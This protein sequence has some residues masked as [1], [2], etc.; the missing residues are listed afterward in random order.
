MAIR[1]Y[2]ENGNTLYEIY[3]HVKSTVDPLV[4]VQRRK[5]NIKTYKDAVREETRITK[6][7]LRELG[8][9]EEKGSTWER[10]IELWY[11]EHFHNDLEGR[12]TNKF[13]LG[14]YKKML[15]RYTKSWLKK[16]PGEITRGDGRKVIEYLLAQGKSKSFI[17]KVR[18]TINLVFQWGVDHRH[19]R[20]AFVP[21]MQGIKIEK[22]EDKFPEILNLTE[23]R[24]FLYEAKRQNHPWYPIWAMAL[25]TG[26]R[27]GELY[28]LEW[29]DVDFE[30]K[31]IR[32][33]K[34]FNK[35]T[36]EI[37][38]TKAGYW[39]NVPVSDELNKLLVELRSITGKEANLLPRN[40]IWDRGEQSKPLRAF[41]V[42]NG[43]P[44]VKFHTLRA[45][46]ATQLLADGV[47]MIKVMK[48]GGW[49]DIKTMQIYL[50]LAGVDERGATDGLRFLP[51]EEAVMGHVVELFKFKK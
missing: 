5:R 45:C 47:E 49:K 13:T 51:S 19:I 46:F 30:H 4:R 1:E 34:S 23:I 14:D 6:E 43:I 7:A 29:N 8:S 12:Y 11:Y 41:L 20:D 9:R 17:A 38:S 50:R 36:G 3:V 21:P 24:K 27:S 16:R 44:S 31:V 28:A 22:R 37:K 40:S 42:E 2:Q 35:R 39:R 32:V 26:M 15:K 18:N 33:T 10:I 48:I 25:L